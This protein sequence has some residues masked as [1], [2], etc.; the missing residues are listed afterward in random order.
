MKHACPH[1]FLNKSFDTL[2]C[3]LFN[4]LA[5]PCK[6]PQT[7]VKRAQMSNETKNLYRSGETIVLGCKPGY[8][9]VGN[10]TLECNEGNWTKSEFYCESEFIYIMS[11]A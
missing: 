1:Y 3:C 9:V 4:C 11:R 2:I 10:A 7:D 6:L 8:R 5:I